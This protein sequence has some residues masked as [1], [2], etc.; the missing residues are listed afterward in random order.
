MALQMYDLTGAD[1]TI[2]FS[3]FCWRV[4]TAIAVKGLDVETIPWRFTET[5]KLKASGQGRVPVLIDGE[6]VVHDS[7]SIALHLDTAYPDRPLMRDDAARA[8]AKLTEAWTNASIFPPLRPLA[9]EPVHRLLGDFDGDYFRTSREAA[10]K[11]PLAVVSS[12][13]A[14]AEATLA[15]ARVLKSLEPVLAEHDFL[16]GGEPYYGDCIVF[17]TLMWPYI[18]N[19][20]FTLDTETHTA[21]WFERMLDAGGGVGRSAKRAA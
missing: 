13:D 5:D 20:A 19:S 21:K 9:V 2:R 16:G 7:W 11:A 8:A 4:R 6:T 15:L 3:P 17:G 10:L 1:D 18:V 14:Q 12:A